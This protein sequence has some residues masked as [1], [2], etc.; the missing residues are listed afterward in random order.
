[1]KLI[2]F[3]FVELI[4]FASC[5]CSTND[6]YGIIQCA[7]RLYSI[8]A[9]SSNKN[10]DTFKWQIFANTSK[11]YFKQVCEYKGRELFTVVFYTISVPSFYLVHSISFKVVQKLTKSSALM[12]N[13]LKANITQLILY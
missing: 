5:Y 7:Q 8:N 1:M 9:F 6:Q 10:G 3:C 13:Q 4:H 12:K 2:K 11:T